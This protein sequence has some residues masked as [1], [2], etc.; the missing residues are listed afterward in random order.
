MS[1]PVK[2]DSVTE[3]RIA[4][5]LNEAQQAMHAKKAAEQV[6]HCFKKALEQIIYCQ[7]FS[8]YCIVLSLKS[9]FLGSNS[10]F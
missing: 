1:N 2:D 7:V 10:L 8:M 6:I 3:D 9:Q 4:S 5:I